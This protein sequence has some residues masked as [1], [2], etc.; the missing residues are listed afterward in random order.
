MDPWDSRLLVRTSPRATPP[1]AAA[2]AGAAC[3]SWPA[4]DLTELTDLMDPA[5]EGREEPGLWV[6]V[7][8]VFLSSALWASCVLPS[9]SKLKNCDSLCILVFSWLIMSTS[10]CVMVC[11]VLSMSLWITPAILNL[12]VHCLFSFS[13]VSSSM[14]S[15]KLSASSRS[16]VASSASMI[17]S[18]S[19][20]LVAS[21]IFKVADNSSSVASSLSSVSSS[22]CS[23]FISWIV[24]RTAISHW[25]VVAVVAWH[26]NSAPISTCVCFSTAPGGASEKATTV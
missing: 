10:L 2:A 9:V 12:A 4:A 1:S 18:L 11:C 20:T 5:E 26:P 13:T 3:A 16:L 24:L 17:A 14:V 21:R 19:L 7:W 25:S 8:P 22:S 15:A 23:S 6:G